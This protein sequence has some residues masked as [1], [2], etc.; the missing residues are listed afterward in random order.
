MIAI[1]QC[2]CE[3]DSSLGEIFFFFID[4]LANITFVESFQVIITAMLE[5]VC[6]ISQPTEEQMALFIEIFVSRLPE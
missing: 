5:S 3:D 6:A 2:R 4:E 1:E